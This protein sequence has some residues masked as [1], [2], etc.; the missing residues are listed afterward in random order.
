M[1]ENNSVPVL[2]TLA[3]LFLS[4]SLQKRLFAT[5]HILTK[6]SYSSMKWGSHTVDTPTQQTATVNEMDYS[7]IFD[8]I[9]FMLRTC[10]CGWIS[11]QIDAWK[12]LL[13]KHTTELQRSWWVVIWIIIF[14]VWVQTGISTMMASWLKCQWHFLVTGFKE[15]NPH[16]TTQNSYWANARLQK[17]A[18]GSLPT[19]CGHLCGSG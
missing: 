15:M 13:R 3:A 9:N 1:T 19:G 11:L 10:S 7:Q 16:L 17:E 5:L 6:Y 4:L 8:D 12:I 18:Q 2:L 14:H